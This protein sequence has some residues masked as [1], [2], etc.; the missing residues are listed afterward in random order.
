MNGALQNW[1]KKIDELDEELL[2]VLAKRISLVR[3]IGKFKK[4]HNISIFDEKRWNKILES[5]LLK[6]KTMGLPSELIKKLYALIHKYSRQ[7]QEEGA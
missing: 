1:R 5:S 6:G 7:I 2:F 4:Q 3:K